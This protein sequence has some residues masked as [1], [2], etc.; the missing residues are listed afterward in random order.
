MASIKER[1]YEYLNAKQLKA[2]AFERQCKLGNGFCSKINDNVSDGSLSLI[3]K[4]APDLNINWLKTGFG[5]MLNDPADLV[6]S[7]SGDP[8]MLAMVRMMQEFIS[9]GKKNSDANLL[10]AE[11]NRINARNLERLIDLIEHKL[12]DKQPCQ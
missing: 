8:N 12:L 2:F 3:E 7:N 4:G 10:N 1:L 9:L 11:A 5:E 6:N